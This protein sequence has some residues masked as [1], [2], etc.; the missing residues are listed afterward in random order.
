MTLSHYGLRWG[1]DYTENPT[2]IVLEAEN[3]KSRYFDN[4]N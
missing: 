2:L 4:Q 3:M 1:N